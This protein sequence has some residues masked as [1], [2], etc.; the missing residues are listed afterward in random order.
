M[1]AGTAALPTPVDYP[2]VVFNGVPLLREASQGLH[3]LPAPPDPPLIASSLGV[4]TVDVAE[5]N[6]GRPLLIAG[7][8][9]ISLRAASAAPRVQL[10]VR[11]ID[12]AP[13]GSQQ[14][15]TRGTFLLEGPAVDASVTIS[16]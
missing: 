6:S 4:F 13:D 3:P 11:L 8:P 16:T 15:I 9:A 2:S 1:Y 10:D 5:L 14:L 12:V 7:Q